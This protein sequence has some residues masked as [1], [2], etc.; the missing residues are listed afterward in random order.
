MVARKPKPS[1]RSRA[2]PEDEP[3]V[4]HDLDIVFFEIDNFLV[5]NIVA[6][7]DY[8]LS[9]FRFVG[10]RVGNS[11]L[12]P[13]P[14]KGMDI[15]PRY[16]KARFAERTGNVQGPYFRDLRCLNNHQIGKRS[17]LFPGT[18]DRNIQ[19][20]REQ[21]LQVTCH[22]SAVRGVLHHHVPP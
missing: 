9:G 20:A 16:D 13:P 18:K 22:C 1:R 15:L 21:D 3:N 2:V 7:E 4:V 19:D 8:I 5:E 12:N 10:F 14:G 6:E 17:Y 11:D